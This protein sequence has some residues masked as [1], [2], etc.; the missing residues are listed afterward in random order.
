MSVLWTSQDAAKATGGTA[1]GA[2]DAIGVSIDTRSIRPGEL[3]VALKDQ[4]DGHDFVADALAKGAAAAMVSHVPEGVSDTDR[5]LVVD[6]VL[7]ALERLGKA[8]RARTSAKVIGITGSVGKTS[9]KE[10]LRAAL[11][12]SG[13]THAAERSF[14][15]HWGVPLTLARMPKDSD[16][17]V[18][19]IGMN[20]PGEI[21]PLARLA[22][23]DVA[24][25]TTVAAVHLEAFEN[26]E[27]IAVE[28]ASIFDGLRPD[29]IAIVNAD[30][31]TRPV[32]EDRLKNI[33]TIWYGAA[34]DADP[35]LERMTPLDIGQSVEFLWHGL[36]QSFRLG[37]EGQHFAINALGVLAAVKSVGADVPLAMNA[38]AAWGSPAG[39]GQQMD[40]PFGE[41]TV[42][43]I[44]ESYNANPTSMAAALKVLV[45]AKDADR[46][47]ACLGDMLELGEDEHI[48]HAG[49]AAL[50]ELSKV[51]QVYCV[52]PLMKSLFDALPKEKRGVWYADTAAALTGFASHLLPG[53]AVMIK[54][55]NGSG[56]HRIVAQLKARGEG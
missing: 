32:V 12:P 41:G 54:G 49:L 16:F 50:P 20:A 28:K 2:W 3:F 44:D 4:R 47:V 24:M 39:R 11:A 15:N 38:L 55:S 27:G 7:V 42:R 52:G 10:M 35:I 19:E 48:L 37:A 13:K 30:F 18:I 34:A 51:D 26:I 6:D 21:S 46:R 5:L 53:D 40:L 31:D 56:V 14:N 1:T 23:L 33:E 17:A 43:L 22:D 8:A 29:G 45:A 36:D 9:T 25:V